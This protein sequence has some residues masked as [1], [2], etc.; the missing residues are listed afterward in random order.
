MAESGPFRRAL[1]VAFRSA[2]AAACFTASFDL[3]ATVARANQPV[4]RA[5]WWH[6]VAAAVG[7][8]GAAAVVL[9]LAVG[10]VA[11]GVIAT[12]SVRTSLRGWIASVRSDADRDRAHAA[13]VLAA[14]AA[15]GLLGAIVFGYAIAIGFEMSAKRNGALSTAMI[16]IAAAPLCTLAWFPL[17][18]A[19]RVAALIVPR[20][21]ALVVIGAL[22]ALAALGV[23]GAVASVD[24]RIIDFGPVEALAI[25]VASGAAFAAFVYGSAP[26][27]K[28]R[29]RLGRPYRAA[30]T[31]G[32]AAALAATLALT[33]TSFGHEPRSLAL[34]GE[35]S[36]GA[37][38][39]LRIA[40]RFADHDHDGYAGRLGGGDCN[41][42]DA[43]IHPGAEEIRGNHVDEDCDGSDAPALDA[44]VAP[45]PSSPD[46]ASAAAQKLAWKGNLIIIT[47]DTLRVDRLAMM[48]RTAAFA[49]TAVAFTHA[50]AQAPNTPR[51]FPSF[52]TSRFP[53][54]VKWVRMNMNFPPIADSPDNTT[55]FEP[56]HAAGLYTVGEFSHFYMKP[57][58]GIARGFDLWKNDDAL[59]LHDSNTDISAPRITARVVARL[60]ELKRSG[61]R[62][63]LWTHLFEPHSRYMDHDEFPTHSSGLKGLEEKYDGEVKFDDKY[64]GEILDA[65]DREGLAKDTAV[66]IFS[67]HGEAFGEHRFGGERMYFHG[68]TL[69]D[70]LLRVP[71]L[72]RV[73][74]VAPRTVDAAVMLVD[75]GPTLCDLVKAPRPASFRGRSLL[76]AIVGDPLP[77]RPAYA[78]LLPTPSWNHLWRAIIDGNAKLI[79]KISE[80]TTE[81]YDLRKD[82]TEQVN[83]AGENGG[84]MVRMQELLRTFLRGGAR[85]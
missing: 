20:P 63:A 84:E 7:L 29:E 9:A 46:A 50:Y 24:W 3:I 33:W 28:L 76:A 16:A 27:R 4:P 52:L 71:L 39:L 14:A 42:H 19:A 59:T 43:R 66:V 72:V 44:R 17:Y 55:F 61:K 35:E 49:K 68:Q 45:P 34:I 40:R 25:L 1:A 23:I 81:L 51:S 11:G 37:K 31:W 5:A 83:L 69:Y 60:A 47:I 73:P 80:N 65:L 21:R 57:E 13:G 12:F 41:D 77:P 6:A 79:H 74:G 10:V 70:E 26:G 75:L 54:E 15:L 62:F 48:P 38:V 18:R 32:T 56:L 67:D 58:N 85:G 8:Y 82:P 53:S 30:A 78:E 22:G 2:L 64:I 36:M